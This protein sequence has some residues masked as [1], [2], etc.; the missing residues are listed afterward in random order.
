LA[1]ANSGAVIGT[2]VNE[3]SELPPMVDDASVLDVIVPV[4]M[5]DRATSV[6]LT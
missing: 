2:V 1:P 5:F 6:P 4:G 3:V